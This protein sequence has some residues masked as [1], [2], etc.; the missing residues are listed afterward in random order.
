[1]KTGKVIEKGLEKTKEDTTE[2]N[3][4]KK[5]KKKRKKRVP[6]VLPLNEDGITSIIV[7]M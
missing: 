2:S 7:H 1:M 5:D 6:P 4:L 3:V